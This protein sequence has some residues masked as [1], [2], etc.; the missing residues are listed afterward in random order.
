M[1]L[2][3]DLDANQVADDPF[4]VAPDKYKCI[5]TEASLKEKTD[6]SGFGLAFKWVITDEDSEYEG[7]NLSDWLNVWPDGVDEEDMTAAIK[8]AMSRTKM[9]LIQMGLSSDQMNTLLD[10]ES[11]LD[12]LVGMEAYV[13]VVETPDK[14]DP[15]K[16]WTNI[17]KVERIYDED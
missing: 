3:G 2:F 13:D 5:L 14:N 6:Q 9:R 11:N 4:Y 7:Q 10:E 16:K 17:R 12:L 1:G 8:Q 15:D